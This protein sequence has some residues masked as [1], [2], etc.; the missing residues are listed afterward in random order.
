MPLQATF[1][2]DFQQFTQSLRDASV[3]LQVFD[4]ATK[5]ATRDLKR[6]VESF[7]G[8][9]LATE[10]ARMAEAISRVGGTSKL[11]E[12]E[13]ARARGVVEQY[14]EKKTVWISVK[15]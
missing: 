14:T 10:A 15:P 7:S 2:A 8:Q 1:A 11:T 12:S 5:T 9:N 4:R 3:Q 6:E 13:L